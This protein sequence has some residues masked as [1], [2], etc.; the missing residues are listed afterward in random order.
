MV[1]DVAKVISDCNW[2]L[3]SVVQ[4]RIM[5]VSLAAHFEIRD[6]RV[7][8]RYLLQQRLDQIRPPSF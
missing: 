5:E 2:K 7:P 6:Q 1:P 4:T 3:G 8:V